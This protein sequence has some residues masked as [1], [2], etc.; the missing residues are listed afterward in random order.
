MAS[1]HKAFTNSS[2]VVQNDNGGNALRSSGKHRV[3]AFQQIMKDTTNVETHVKSMMS[4]YEN[5]T[6]ETIQHQILLDIFV[7]AFYKRS[8]NKEGI[9][10][11]E[12]LRNVFYQYIFALYDLY[13]KI[14]CDF[15]KEGLFAVYGYWKDYLNIWKIANTRPKPYDDLINAL[16]EGIL[17]QRGKDIKTLRAFCNTCGFNFDRSTVEE[18]REF[19][20]SLDSNTISSLNISYVGKYCVREGSS[21]NKSCYKILN[22]GKK[23][24]HVPFMI[25]K[26]ISWSNGKE[27]TDY[28]SIPYGAHKHWR[29]INSKLNIIL[30]V[31]EIKFCAQKWSELKISSI[32]SVCFHKNTKALL[33]E[34]KTNEEKFPNNEDRSKCR[35]NVISHVKSN[36]KINV[37]QLYPN[38]IACSSRNF[39]NKSTIEKELTE[40][41]WKLLLDYIDIKMEETIDSMNSSNKTFAK[42]NIICCPDV[43]GSMSMTSYGTEPNRPIDLAVS[44]SIFC[45]QLASEYYRNKIMT[46]SQNPT[47]VQLDENASLEDKFKAVES[48][49]WDMNTNYERLHQC[50]IQLCVKHSVPEEELPVLVIFTDGHFDSMVSTESNIDIAHDIVIKMW[51]ASGYSRVPLMVYWNLNANNSAIQTYSN[52]KGIISLSGPSPNNIKYILYG[53]SAE[54][55]T[56]SQIIDGEEIISTKKNISPYDIFRKAMDQ[57]YF[58]PIKEIVNKN[59]L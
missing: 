35:E 18:F 24:Y 48:G 2:Y 52:S 39:A 45:S 30:D 59:I 44:L 31:P 36:K 47:I 53:E 8:T 42:G 43:S 4:E 21:F 56:E 12:G 41:K 6:N 49:I 10:E 17:T 37:E 38:M 1:F 9:C 11:G 26:L 29:I 46:F 25:R 3:D 22:N 40:Y 32:P 16:R 54:D 57:H 55:I 19:V 51:N 23:E 58:K 20:K 15:A 33:N 34:T 7:L 50:L 27:F 28:E 13:P 5:E 14:V